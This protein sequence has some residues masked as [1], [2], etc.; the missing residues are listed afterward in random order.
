MCGIVATFA[1]GA[2]APPVTAADVTFDDTA[3]SPIPDGD[4]QI[5]SGSYRPAEYV[6]GFNDLT[7]LRNLKRLR[8]LHLENLRRVLGLNDHKLA[9]RGRTRI[10]HLD[11]RLVAV[12]IDGD[13][14]LPG[15][16]R[17]TAISSQ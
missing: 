8:A 10:D 3:A 15:R 6:S 9:P 1:Y 2:G 11:P 4:G 16:H 14:Q 7:P 12:V 5:V 13:G 17:R